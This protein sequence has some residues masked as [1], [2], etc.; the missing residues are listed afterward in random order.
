MILPSTVCFKN[1]VIKLKQLQKVYP[2]N[3]T[4]S[5]HLLVY[6]SK[7]NNTYFGNN[8]YIQMICLF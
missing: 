4:L 5:I 7:E 1:I 6:K 8:I 2:L 3:H